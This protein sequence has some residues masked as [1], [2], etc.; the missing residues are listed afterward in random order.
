[1]RESIVQLKGKT[2]KLTR[3]VEETKLELADLEANTYAQIVANTRQ[4]LMKVS[5]DSI[6][7]EI[8]Q[9]AEAI[10]IKADKIDL[11]GLVEADEFVAKYAS[12]STLEATEASLRNLIAQKATIEELNAVNVTVEGKLDA[13]DFTAENISAMN[14]K[15]KSANIE[16]KLTANQIDVEGLIDST[17]FIGAAITVQA[18]FATEGITVDE[19]ACTYIPL[20]DSNGQEIYCLGYYKKDYENV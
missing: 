13:K 16:G 10:T 20:K 4:I 5:K 6:I 14:I 18:L 12:V 9:T 8:N 1:M 19:K 11:V 15:V 3:T 7:S 17:I 2:S